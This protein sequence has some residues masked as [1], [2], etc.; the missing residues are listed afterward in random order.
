M[1]VY[2]L[3]LLAISTFLFCPPRSEAATFYVNVNG[4]NPVFPYSNWGTAATN[5]QDSVDAANP[6]DL[7]LVTNGTYQSGGRVV[8][9]SLTNRLAV[10]KPLLVQSVNGPAVTFIQGNPAIGD[11]AVRCVYLTNGAALSG[12]TLLN[13][14]TRAGGDGYKEQCGGA[15][16]C[17][18]VNASITNCILSTNSAASCGGAAFRGTFNNCSL[19]GNIAYGAGGGGF[20]NVLNGCLIS[21]NQATTAANNPSGSTSGG[22]LESCIASNCVITGNLTHSDNYGDDAGGGANN[23]RLYSCAISNNWA[24]GEGGGAA[25]STLQF[26]T[27]LGNRADGNGGGGAS[28]SALLNCLIV[29][30]TAYWGAGL[31]NGSATNCVLQQNISDAQGGG[32]TGSTLYNCLV[33]GNSGSVGGGAAAN[34]SGTGTTL[35]NCTVYGNTASF[36][37]GGMDS[38]TADNSII[39]SN[40]STNQPDSSNWYGGT[41]SH[42]C[43]LPLPGAGTGNITNA[44]LFLDPTGND[45]HLQSNS[46]CINSGNNAYVTNIVDLDGNLRLL[47]GSVDMGPYEFHLAN[48]PIISIQANHTNVVV[49]Y[50]VDFFGSSTGGRSD[51]WNFGDG[52]VI[53][54][55]WSVTH[56][57]SATGD[58]AV[59]LTLF[60]SNYPNGASTNFIIHVIPPPVLY[61]NANGTSPVAPYSSWSTAATNIQNAIDVAEAGY[62][63]LVTNGVYQVGGKVTSDGVTNRVAVTNSVTILSVN[64]SA[65]TAIDGGHVMRC[66]YLT[67]G[68]SL[69]GF[70]L[71]NGTAGNGG[72]LYCTSTNAFISNCALV[73]NTATS[74]GGAYSG[75]LTNCAF[76]GNTCPLT[77]GNGGGAAGSTLFNCT[78]SGNVTGRAYPNTTGASWGGGASGGLL[79]NCTLSGNSSYG[80]GSHGAG[81]SGATLN[82]CMLLNNYTDNQGGGAYNCTLNSCLLTGNYGVVG[83]GATSGTLNNC[84][85]VNN[86]S[87][88]NGGGGTYYLTANNCI[89]VNNTAPNN[90]ASTLNYCCTPDGGLGCITNAPL[91]VNQAGGDYHLQTYSP[92]INAGTNA[93]VAT[94]LDLDGNPR[95]VGGT[96]DCGAYENQSA[97]AGAGLPTIPTALTATRSGGSALLN[98]PASTR[99]TSYAVYRATASGGPFTKIASGVLPTNYTDSTIASGGTYFYF[100]T[101]GNAYGETVSSPVAVIYYVDHFAFAPIGPQTSSVP[102][103]V[104]ISA[105]DSGGLVLSN[106]NGLAALRAAG[107]LGNVLLTP[108]S[109]AAFANGQ[110]SGT[111]T[112]DPAYPDTNIRLVANSNSV[113][114]LSNPFNVVAPAIQVFNL[115]L[116]DMVYVPAARRIYATVPASAAAYSNSLLVIDPQIGRVETNWFIGNDP[117]CLALS[118]DGQSLY[119]GFGGT[120]AFARYN[121]ANHAIDFETYLGYDSQY[122]WLAE[123]AAHFTVLPG[124]PNSMAVVQQAY[125]LNTKVQIFDDGVPRAGELAGIL[126]D[127]PGTLAA[128]SPTRLYAGSPFTRM[129]VD[130]S[131]VVSHDNPSAPLS[132]G[133]T[134]KWQGGLLFTA[135]GDVFNPET[136]AIMGTLTNSSIVTP[137]LAS[138]RILSMGSHPVFG[139]PDAWTLYSWNAT[140]LQLIASLPIPGVNSGGPTTL[141]RWGTNG[142]AFFISSS[143]QN[144]FFLVRT[145]MVPYVGPAATVGSRPAAGPF[146]LNFIGDESMPYAIVGS[147][148][149]A[150]WAPLGPPNLV[151]NSHFWFWDA[152]ITNYPH[153]FYR[154]GIS[155]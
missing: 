76:S 87:A 47:D 55:Q 18:S 89:I 82:N 92:C 45:F 12:F 42:C 13:G 63:I 149:L 56:A 131:G 36:R 126:N 49:G 132:N 136:M 97:T 41:L 103:A 23:S 100:V 72:G 67:N 31:N 94:S 46:P 16:W 151:S 121:L 69:V 50:P 30:N 96:T 52:N 25:N 40:W 1:R 17:E 101:A 11:S 28:G 75:T 111:V 104:T 79:F 98:W 88:G 64:G 65:V 105:C 128:A 71:T 147:T 57:W 142:A 109:T 19:I 21:S 43:T 102:F 73:N 108:T 148:D 37:A 113:A 53:S 155:Q 2:Y 138:G 124:Q 34:P 146:Q 10:G 154:V 68:A 62:H 86:H 93:Y 60:D 4:N 125:G 107:D 26:C 90:F 81:A 22:G 29:S 119:V 134:L 61:V 74:G 15:V 95:I 115:T 20:S 120:N 14:A 58:Y 127:F 6:G 44:P 3:A 9:G 139:Q 130:A 35:I 54:N 145:P 133:E 51:S 32:A 78:L 144:Q 143:Y 24:H 141:I 116:N 117:G 33:A 7:I 123:H 106:F 85:I 110:W 59:T 112:V 152:N 99:A 83:G 39:L 77:G 48:P 129:T 153:R 80:A 135:S 5:I 122:N 8:Y 70:T 27:L 150:N 91:F 38:S 140:N 84:T 66:V 118:P 137:D 114:G